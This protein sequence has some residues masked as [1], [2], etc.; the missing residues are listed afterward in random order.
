MEAQRIQATLAAQPTT[1]DFDHYRSVLKNKAIVSEAEKILKEFNPVTYDVSTHI[2]AIETFET[3]AVST[4][5][6]GFSFIFVSFIIGYDLRVG[7]LQVAKAVETSSKIDE[8]L[9]DLQAT[10]ANIESARPFEDLTVRV[11]PPNFSYVSILTSPPAGR[12]GWSCSPQN[13]RGRGDNDEEG[14]MDCSW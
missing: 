8:E 14:Q 12:R 3:K 11:S 6:Y 1:I 10:L 2:K 13:H 4:F 7:R 5:L 9:E